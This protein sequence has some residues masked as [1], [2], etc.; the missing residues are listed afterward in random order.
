MKPECDGG[1]LRDHILLPSYICPVVLVSPYPCCWVAGTWQGIATADLPSLAAGAAFT[2]QRARPCLCSPKDR[3]SH[4]RR[5]ESDSPASTSPE[6]NQA[7]KFNSTT[8]DGQGLQVG[9][10]AGLPVSSAT[11]TC[12]APQRPGVRSRAFCPPDQPP[13]RDAPSPGACEPQEW[14]K[15]RGAVGGV[16]PR[17]TIP[18]GSGAASA[19]GR[20]GTCPREGLASAASLT[21]LLP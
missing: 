11:G 14:R 20:P 9:S 4:C 18:L 21:L 1:L 19:S 2:R 12:Q 5:S 15:T 17:E 10:H 16:L 7:F 3:Q 6:D 13:A 8:V